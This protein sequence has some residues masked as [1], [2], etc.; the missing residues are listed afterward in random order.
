MKC[1]E[2][3]E[4]KQGCHI[5]CSCQKEQKIPILDLAFL[6]SQRKKIEER[7]KLIAA[8]VDRLEQIRHKR[9][10]DRSE[11]LK[12]RDIEKKNRI[13]K[14]D[15]EMQSRIEKD[16]E[17]MDVDNVESVCNVSDDNNNFELNDSLNN[18]N[19][20]DI[21][22]LAGASTRYGISSRVPGAFLTAYLGDLIKAGILPPDAAY[23]SVDD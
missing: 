4:C 15:I 2:C 14:Q 10:D 1:L 6:D 20:I 11:L 9:K 12:R 23:L 3:I 5:K 22:G 18:R 17:Q 19:R 16:E 21:K 8:T 13:E 7:G